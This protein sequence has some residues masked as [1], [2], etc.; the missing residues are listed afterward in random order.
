MWAIWIVLFI[1]FWCFPLKSQVPQMNVQRSA[2]FRIQG[3]RFA[4]TWS[5]LWSF[6]LVLAQLWVNLASLNSRLRLPNSARPLTSVW[7]L[8][9]LKSGNFL[10]SKNWAIVG[11][12]FIFIIFSQWSLW[13]FPGGSEVRN[14]PA[15]TGD[16]DLIPGLED[17]LGKEMAA[18]S[19]ILAWEMP[20]T[21]EPE[22][23][24]SLGLQ[25]S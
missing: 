6:S 7:V 24:Q 11:F 9:V 13:G 14:L 16:V 18:H 23:L 1:L 8:P 5:N 19:S 12:A 20:W 4:D 15:S 3:D 17:I 21:E 25:K 2:Y 10:Y 22:G